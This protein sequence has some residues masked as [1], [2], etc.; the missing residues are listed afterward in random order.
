MNKLTIIS[1]LIIFGIILA[2]WLIFKN[3][4]VQPKKVS[5]KSGDTYFSLKEIRAKENQPIDFEVENEGEHTFVIDEL[6]V[7]VYLEQGKNHFQI[8]PLR[9]GEFIYYCD[10]PGHKAAGQWGKIIVE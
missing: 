3:S 8:T 6:G 2:G 5:F 4:Q 7:R 9:K 1:L 10:I